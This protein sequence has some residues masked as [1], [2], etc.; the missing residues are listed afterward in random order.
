M[1]RPDFDALCRLAAE[2]G[3]ASRARGWRLATAESCTGGLVA[4][5]LTDVAGSS[6]WFEGGVVAYDN[7]V[8]MRL[9]GVPEEILIRHGAV[10]QACVES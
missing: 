10:S 2:V 4:S 7:R 8:K 5:T 6:R 3:A 1:T 9:L